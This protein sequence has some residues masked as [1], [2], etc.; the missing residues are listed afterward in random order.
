MSPS[1]GHT[2]TQREEIRSASIA[3]ASSH[4]QVSD[5]D[6]EKAMQSPPVTTPR[7]AIRQLSPLPLA[8]PLPSG[9]DQKASDSQME[10]KIIAEESSLSCSPPLPLPLHTRFHPSDL[11]ELQ[12]AMQP[13]SPSQRRIDIEP[14]HTHMQTQQIEQSTQTK[15][16]TTQHTHST[17]ATL[18]EA[19][20]PSDFRL[21]PFVSSLISGATDMNV[22]LDTQ[23]DMLMPPEYQPYESDFRLIFT[24]RA[25]EV[26]QRDDTAPRVFSRGVKETSLE[27]PATHPLNSV[28]IWSGDAKP[29]PL[30]CSASSFSWLLPNLLGKT[31]FGLYP[32]PLSCVGGLVAGAASRWPHTESQDR[33]AAQTTRKQP[34]SEQHIED[35]GTSMMRNDEMEQKEWKS[36]QPESETVS[37]EFGSS[38]AALSRCSTPASLHHYASQSNSPASSYLSYQTTSPDVSCQSSGSAQSGCSL[39]GGDRRPKSAPTDGGSEEWKFTTAKVPIISN[40]PIIVVTHDGAS[41]N[42][43]QSIALCSDVSTLR[44]PPPASLIDSSATIPTSR[45]C[46]IRSSP[47]FPP[48]HPTISFASIASRANGQLPTSASQPTEP[49]TGSITTATHASNSP[50]TADTSQQLA[51]EWSEVGKN[52]KPLFKSATRD[53]KKKEASGR[54]KSNHTTVANASAKAKV[55]KQATGPTPSN[56][57]STRGSSS[58]ST[59]VSSSSH[60]SPALGAAAA[61]ASSSASPVD[62][63]S[64]APCQTEPTTT[65]T[66]TTRTAPTGEDEHAR[67]QTTVTANTSSEKQPQPLEPTATRTTHT[68]NQSGIQRQHKDNHQLQHPV[69][70]PNQ[71]YPHPAQLPYPPSFMPFS[72]VYRFP[73]APPPHPGLL[74][75]PSGGPIHPFS[76]PPFLGYPPYGVP[77]AGPHMPPPPHHAHTPFFDQHHTPPNMTHTPIRPSQTQHQ[78][79]QPPTMMYAHNPHMAMQAWT[80]AKSPRRMNMNGP[81]YWP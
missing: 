35:K 29:D 81:I 76:F 8:P 77:V 25:I 3:M 38:S 20:L 75:S 21:S 11:S 4:T 34:I 17:S 2:V 41:S 43:G 62:L 36:Q 31:I 52:G 26:K 16:P 72:P 32:D 6:Q 59:S 60:T 58:A 53:M 1:V 49:N 63:P 5:M 19:C 12:S 50:A 51:A 55:L 70:P 22:N 65:P 68:D 54:G 45:S 39:S 44:L 57:I 40:S 15:Q 33:T 79:H 64:T 80:H 9:G 66:S 28:S 47:T 7:R 13:H 61:G 30:D 18:E 46:P 74:V 14:S 78:R 10:K 56:S 69:Y 71:L 23:L 67:N 48:L 42:F 73:L 24:Q 37:S 27:L